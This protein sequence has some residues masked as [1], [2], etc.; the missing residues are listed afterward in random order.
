MRDEFNTA[1][2]VTLACIVVLLIVCVC[3]IAFA[4]EIPLE[5]DVYEHLVEQC[6]K[7][8]IPVELVLAVIETESTF[9]A[10]CVNASETCYG[11]MQ[12][13]KVNFDWL[14]E[15]FDR[16]MDFLDPFD[17]IDAGVYVLAGYYHKY[18]DDVHR[19]LAA[20]NGGESYARRLWR[21][22]Y[23][24]TAYSRLVVERMTKYEQD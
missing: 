17:N 14:E 13:H 7:R 10:E 19:A 18:S 6:E 20:Y 11:L 21:N 4:V 1:F 15:D 23:E 2:R 3:G 8:E 22:G 9:D 16:D 5:A 12:I 24:S